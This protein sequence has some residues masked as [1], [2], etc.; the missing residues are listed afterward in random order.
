MKEI[1]LDKFLSDNTEFTRSEVK[2]FIFKGC[3]NVNSQVVKK[4]DYKINP[5]ADT[6]SLSGERIDFKPFVYVLLNKPKGVVSASNDKAAKTV[7]DLAPQQLKH[8]ELFPVGRLDKETTGILLLTNDGEFAHRVISPK[9]GIEKEYIAE[10]DADV[11]PDV[12]QAFA[13]GI[14]LADGYECK[15]AKAEKINDRTVRIILTEGK[16]H[17]IK[18][19]LGTIG[20]GVNELRRV[21]IGGLELPKELKEGDSAEI[22]KITSNSV[23]KP[24]KR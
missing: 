22:D 15:A 9:S 16:Y 21:R 10:V 6:V 1:R 7:V 20:L 18:R 3:V 5:E 14:T 24:K 11:P 17:Q 2:K 19:M 4:I 12:G 13:S 8:Y 23:F